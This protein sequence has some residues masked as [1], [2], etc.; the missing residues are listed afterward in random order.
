MS[1]V[2]LPADMAANINMFVHNVQAMLDTEMGSHPKPKVRVDPRGRSKLRVYLDWTGTTREFGLRGA[3]L[4]DDPLEVYCFIRVSDG[5]IL[6][7]TSWS[8]VVYAEPLVSR[9]TDEDFGLSNCSV[10]GVTYPIPRD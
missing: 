9:I 2:L 5:A 8:N 4:V 3:S 1:N 6:K 10:H 7:A